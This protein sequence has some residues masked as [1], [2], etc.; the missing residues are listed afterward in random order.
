MKKCLYIAALALC[1]SGF[2]QEQNR[3]PGQPQP[4]GQPAPSQ[5][6]VSQ[7][8]PTSTPSAPA[9]T[10]E[11]LKE[12]LSNLT[13]DWRLE[14]LPP[15]VQ[16]T[17]RDQSGGQK[18]ADIDR[19]TR[20]GRIV[21]EVEFE[22]EGKNTEIHVADDGNLMPES[23]SAFARTQDQT[24]TAAR[25]GEGPTAT[26]TPAGTQTGRSGIAM[27][28][29]TKWED[30]PKAVQDKAMQFGGKDKVADIDRED[31][32]GK[33]A[34]EIEFRRQGRNLEIHFGE[35]GTILESND[36]SAAQAQGSAPATEAGR[37]P[38]SAQQPQPL[39]PA[40]TVPPT[41]P[42]QNNPPKE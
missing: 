28:T 32:R 27:A 11:R 40:R 41:Q 26:G 22:K 4:P 6:T 18:I 3:P 17:V 34:Y 35:D 2:A 42:N 7:R 29:G 25:P 8:P 31:L 23:D 5:P 24:G 20:T 19:E 39:P 12:G 36:P 30:L 16:K 15:A 37:T 1:S 21:W 33:L 13:T 38:P 9:T 14:D 10:T